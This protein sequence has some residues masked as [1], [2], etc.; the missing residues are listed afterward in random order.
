MVHDPDA[1]AV[2]DNKIFRVPPRRLDARDAS[3]LGY[4]FPVDALTSAAIR[5]GKQGDLPL[6]STSSRSK[7]RTQA[8]AIHSIFFGARRQGATKKNGEPKFPV[9]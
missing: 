3:A 4:R 2:R 8:H 7:E 6:L 1:S 9:S 5:S